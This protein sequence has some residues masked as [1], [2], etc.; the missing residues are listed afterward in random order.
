VKDDEL[1]SQ[2][3]KSLEALQPFPPR[4]PV[5]AVRG[6]ANFLRQANENN[7]EILHEKDYRTGN[8]LT[9][10][11]PIFPRKE[12]IPVVNT[13]FAVV[14]VIAALFGGT[15][16][17]VAAA[18]SSLPDQ[19]LYP[20]KTWSEDALLAMTVSAQTRLR[21]E[22]DFS[23]RRV[24]EISDLLS[25]GKVVPAQVMTRLQNEQ[26]NMLELAAGMNDPLMVQQ[27][28]QVRLRL[29]TQLQIMTG[30]MAR[31]QGSAQADLQQVRDRIQQQ[32]QLAAIGV[33]DPQD[34]RLQVRQQQQV[35]SGSATRTPAS[36]NVP[37]GTATQ[38]PAGT[39]EFTG[40]GYG[41][42][43]GN[44]PQGS[45]T[46][47]PA[48]TPIPTGDSYGPGPGNG[49]QEPGGQN[50]SQT[51]FP[52]RNGDGTGMG[53]NQPTATPGQAGPGS[54]AFTTTGNGP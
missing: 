52:G 5:A 2:I 45:G 21:Y 27:L 30:L 31:S 23:D 1:E 54:P 39:P 11:F 20:V 4:N 9:S 10:I 47:M 7:P 14:M 16:V 24:T 25:A 32:L 50:P 18:Q 26:Q 8:R 3:E 38:N 17:T 41:P 43:P 46:Q 19:T 33:T 35:H 6:R 44:G 51:P 34:F 12:R 15:G 22:L 28:E 49:P 29:E 36:G 37:Q 48:R 42:G 13:L 53:G 40:N